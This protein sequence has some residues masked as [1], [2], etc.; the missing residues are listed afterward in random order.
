MKANGKLPLATITE[1]QITCK[2]KATQDII[3]VDECVERD[4]DVFIFGR[5][6]PT[7]FIARLA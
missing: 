6:R 4:R 2:N 1:K 5:R 3:I 7:E